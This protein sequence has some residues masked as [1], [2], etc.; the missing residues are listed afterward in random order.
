M[1]FDLP[2]LRRK[3]TQ[4]VDLDILPHSLH[5]T[6]MHCLDLISF[7]YLTFQILSNIKCAAVGRQKQPNLINIHFVAFRSEDRVG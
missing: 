6:I 3:Q 4:A 2:S 5:Y 1:K 7:I